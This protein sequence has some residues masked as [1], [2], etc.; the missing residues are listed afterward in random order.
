MDQLV[1][2][3]REVAA[4]GS[5][6]D[7]AVVEALVTSRAAAKDSP[8]KELTPRETEVLSQVAQGRNNAG[9]AAALSLTDRAVEK[10][11]NAIFSKLG[12]SE[13]P[14]THRRVMATLLYLAEH[15]P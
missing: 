15:R 8:L 4:G 14:D 6:I 7:P 1:R 10:H 12:L 5:V 13:Q 2:A 11:I 3:I 9:I